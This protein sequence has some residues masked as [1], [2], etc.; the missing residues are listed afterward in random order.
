[1]TEVNRS[2]RLAARPEGMIK[3]SDFTWHEEPLPAELGP[4]QILVETLY[5]SVDPTQRIWIERDSYLPAVAIGEVVRAGGVARVLRSSLPDFS[6]GDLVYGM[7]GW[8]THAVIEPSIRGPRK[9]PEGV[10]PTMAVSLLGLT[11][12]TAYFG[13]LDVGRP[14]EGETVVVSGAAGATGNAAGQI[15]KIKGCRVVGIAGGPQ[16]CAWIKDELGFDAAIDYKSEDVHE[17]LGELC[18]NGIDVYFDNV[19]GPILEAALS[20]LAMR[21][22]VVLCGSIGDYNNAA[23][24][25]GPRNLMNLVM[26]RG[27]ME[28]FLVSDYAARFGEAI[29]DLARWAAEGRIK[30]RVDVVEG[31]AN[32]PAALR[33]LFTGA[34]TGK[35]LIKVAAG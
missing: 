31:L 34:N 5:L 35:Q 33:R 16:K 17:R 12:L 22:R 30:D 7:T 11:G 24:P 4:G 8:Q 9:L 21:G 23:D 10:S 28:G 25:T 26:K 19:G 2:W 6:P 14:K 1:M 3:D 15:A 29:G 32:A 27:R 18:P 13:L 20:H